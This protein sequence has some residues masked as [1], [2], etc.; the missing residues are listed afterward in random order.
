MAWAWHD[1]QVLANIN[2]PCLSMSLINMLAAAGQVHS[3][4]KLNAPA[5][6][7][8]GGA[9]MQSPGGRVTR[10]R[11]PLSLFALVSCLLAVSVF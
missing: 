1:K 6:G 11:L 10:Q 5:G 9:W 2:P 8:T 7:V 3:Y 4:I